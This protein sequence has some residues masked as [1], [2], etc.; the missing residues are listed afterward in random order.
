LFDYVIVGGGSA[1]AVLASRLAEDAGLRVLLLEAGPRSGGPW[2]RIPLGVAKVLAKPEILW[3]LSTGPEPGLDGSRPSWVSGRLLGGSSAVNGMLFVRGEPARY[4][5]WVAAGGPGWGYAGLL[6]YFQRLEDCPFGSGSARA[7]GG[8]IGVTMVSPDPLSDAF[9]EACAARGFGRVKDY[10][11]ASPD[12]ASYLQLSI[13]KGLREGV[14]DTYLRRARGR[15]NLVIRTGALAHR[16]LI[17][18]GRAVGVRYRFEGAMHDVLAERE[19]VLC[20]GA[21]RSAQLLELS[22]VGD[23]DVLERLGI[24]VV[25]PL[26]GVG[27]NLQDHLM[28]RLAYECTEPVTVNDMVRS[29]WMTAKALLRFAIGRD[30][31]FATPSLTA[32]A[33]VRSEPGLAHP[34]LRIQLGLTSSKSRLVKRGEHGLDPY[35]GFHIG[36]Y[37][38]YPRSRGYT[39]ARSLDPAE[40]PEVVAGYLRAPEDREVA[41]R[42]L[43][44][45]REIAA[46]APLRDFVRREARPGPQAATREQLLEFIKSTGHTCW[47]PVGTCRMG[48]DD[49]AV[50]DGHLRVRGIAGLRVADAS[51]M[52]TLASSNTNIPTIMLAE[53]AADL[54]RGKS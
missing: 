29:P 26:P 20:A 52:P 10:N 49:E 31:V 2:V 28:T 40:P 8:P 54:I 5:E 24:A 14:A 30:G 15:P 42:G 37:P 41:V 11:E 51:V 38:L 18:T 3:T 50:V 48:T 39:H 36:A 13:R 27:R 43:E 53:K 17:D 6:P 32:T 19:I 47:H 44:L 33:F 21:L 12:G 23:P 35:S 22:G 34:D 25:H 46:T 45:V 16:V 1:G 7:R 9:L 4:D